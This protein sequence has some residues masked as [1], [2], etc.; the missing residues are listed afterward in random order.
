M[1]PEE[2]RQA[3]TNVILSEAK[4][5]LFF[6][7]ALAAALQT[8]QQQSLVDKSLHLPK[9]IGRGEAQHRRGD[10]H[11]EPFLNQPSTILRRAVRQPDFDQTLRRISR[12]IIMIE[13]ILRLL[14]CELPVIVDIDHAVDRHFEIRQVLAGLV[15]ALF[16]DPQ[17]LCKLFGG[18]SPRDVT[19]GPR[20]DSAHRLIDDFVTD[21]VALRTNRNPDRRGRLPP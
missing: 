21:L 16:D 2:F 4:N 3:F 8:N 20:A 7:S 19:G 5:L 13:V 10:T 17:A 18:Y 1:T 15:G 6:L 14:V 9:L 11:V 12:T